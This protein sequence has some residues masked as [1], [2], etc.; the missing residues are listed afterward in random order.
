MI[1]VNTGWRQGKWGYEKE[2]KEENK[3]IRNVKEEK[4]GRKNQATRRYRKCKGRKKW[5]KKQEK[6]AKKRSEKRWGVQMKEE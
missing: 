2:N 6:R 4:I 5:K 3:R 1:K